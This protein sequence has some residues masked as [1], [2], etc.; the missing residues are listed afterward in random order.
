MGDLRLAQ[1]LRVYS[2]GEDWGEKVVLLRWPG[3]SEVP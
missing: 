1:L 3:D 2:V